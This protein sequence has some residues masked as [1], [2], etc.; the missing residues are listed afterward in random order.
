MAI[1]VLQDLDERLK[2]AYCWELMLSLR[3]EQSTLCLTFLPFIPLVS[4][5][6]NYF[7]QAQ[8]V[9]R[10]VRDDFDRVFA[11]P[12]HFFDTT[13]KFGDSPSIDVILHPSAIRTAPPLTE[14]GSELEAYVQDTLTVPA[15]LGGLPSLSLPIECKRRK[16]EG[17]HTRW[18]IGLGLVGQWGTD[19][20]V[21]AVAKAI[22]NLE[23]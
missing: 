5:F 2:S 21:L 23:T 15:S 1:L 13:G 10:L 6:D 22:E 9:R 8:R 16:E 4:A 20:L 3:S 12:N 11:I 19:D 7:L 17:A 14:R 18:P